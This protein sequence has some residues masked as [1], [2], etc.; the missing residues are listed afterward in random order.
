MVISYESGDEMEQVG[1]KE[2]L[3][4]VFKKNV[5]LSGL[6][7]GLIDG[8]G[9]PALRSA[10]EKSETKLDDVILLALYQP[11]EDEVKKFVKAKIEALYASIEKSGDGEPV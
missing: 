9:E 8:V 3:V 2:D 11:L 1:L 6:F 4:G 5:N 10:I 7:D